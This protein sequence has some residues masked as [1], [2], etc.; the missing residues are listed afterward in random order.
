[1]ADEMEEYSDGLYERLQN[2]G[3][4]TLKNIYDN[5]INAPGRIKQN[6]DNVRDVN[7]KIKRIR[8]ISN[9][10]HS[11]AKTTSQMSRQ[12]MNGV[13]GL[14]NSAQ[15][16]QTGTKA[17]QA[18]GRTARTGVNMVRTGT[19]TAQ[20]GAK[21]AQMG[22]KASRQIAKA[23][24][25]A[26]KATKE[27]AK[28]AIKA[29]QKFV[30]WTIET[31][32]VF[33]IVVVVVLLVIF[34]IVC[35]YMA[36]RQKENS[37][38]TQSY[39]DN[40]NSLAHYGYVGL[41]SSSSRDTVESLS[42]ANAACKAFYED[43]SK[44]SVWQLQPDGSLINA[45]DED[46]KTDYFKRDE[47]LQLDADFL[48][49]LNAYLFGDQ[50]VYPEVF[51]QPVSYD[52]ENMEL[53]IP[54]DDTGQV[55][56]TSHVR[57]GV[58]DVL[59]ETEY[60]LADYGFGSV[61]TYSTQHITRT[62]TG[63][64]IGEDQWDS[65]NERVVRVNLATPQPF[66]IV[67]YDE[68]V[69]VL[70]NF[71]CMA[72][73]V[74]YNYT[75]RE[76]QGDTVAVGSSSDNENDLV[77]KILIGTHDVVIYKG[78]K[79]WPVY[80]SSGQIEGY[81][82]ITLWDSQKY[83]ESHGYVIDPNT[84]TEKTV[85]MYKYRSASTCIKEVVPVA[86]GSEKT[87][88][89]NGTEYYY[90]YLEKFGCYAPT[91]ATRN[92][93]SLKQITS[94][95]PASTYH[96]SGSNSGTA[97]VSEQEFIDMI[98]PVAQADMEESGILASVTMA[99]CILESGWGKSSLASDYNNYFGIKAGS[100]WD[101]PTVT[102]QTTEQDA[103]GNS[104]TV[105]ASFCVFEDVSDSIRQHSIFLWNTKGGDSYRYRAAAGVTDY[106][107][108]T[109]IIKEGGYATDV[110]YIDKIC[111][112]IEAYN[113]TQY[114]TA[115][116]SGAPPEYADVD[117]ASGGDSG[118]SRFYIGLTEEDREIY[119]NF[120]HAFDNLPDGQTQWTYH[121]TTLT[122]NDMKNILIY[123]NNLRYGTVYS[124]ENV[125]EMDMLT[126]GF[127]GY[128]ARGRRH[129]SAGQF[130]DDFVYYDQHLEPWASYP[131]GKGG[132][133]ID[134]SG[135]GVCCYAMLVS[136]LT[137]E[138]LYPEDA[139]D[140]LVENGYWS[141]GT[142]HSAYTEALPNN[143]S[144]YCSSSMNSDLDTALELLQNG[145][146]IVCSVRGT[147][148]LY[149]GDGHLL[150]IRGVADNGELLLLDPNST[151]RV[152]NDDGTYKSWPEVDV[153]SILI[154]CYYVAEQAP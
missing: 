36:I 129:E 98:A 74:H 22:A 54:V 16:A 122:Q 130:I 77:Q 140:Y 78:T 59:D 108:A 99:Q 25:A 57:D 93:G 2:S 112:I 143:Y 87:Y 120:V 56:V 142:L 139:G 89:D 100:G 47:D 61:V 146:F 68:E 141:G 37:G 123:T 118:Q 38:S 34:L 14:R 26:A 82:T 13:K 72:G 83:L 90:A 147:S 41:D 117:G 28:A 128:M 101:G 60:S 33:L 114:D 132:A 15:A 111:G 12:A 6:I 154:H 32:G 44:Q 52:A 71:V 42:S 50:F 80:N 69:D 35:V 145:G 124:E 125:Q 31:E 3:E 65:E 127:I 45:T 86:S 138:M 24:K 144:L 11:P 17:V 30:E 58:G 48:Y 29:I 67:L 113:L 21:A 96:Q 7:D 110:D 51:I 94:S 109:T 8:D 10:G 62:L 153:Q 19:K 81:K 152:L 119:D 115:T 79:D 137:D 70:D 92:Y 136:N 5:T 9:G 91:G 73:S 102:M 116:W 103:S 1:M 75:S 49:T 97:S 121:T 55:T 40:N 64:Y 39:V 150:L 131:L 149:S 20:A 134:D 27:A 126:D 85:P 148:D 4:D 88:T 95:V 66:S 84:R 151:W 18:G 105:E 106:V 43:L 104:Y 53:V 76:V 107:E 46:A 133:T 23:V 135:C 63:N